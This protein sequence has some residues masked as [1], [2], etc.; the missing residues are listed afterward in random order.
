MKEEQPGRAAQN[1]AAEAIHERSG[2]LL[3]ELRRKKEAGIPVEREQERV[4]RTACR[5][6]DGLREQLL[7]KSISQPLPPRMQY[8][9]IRDWF[10]ARE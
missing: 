8:A 9:L 6:M 2:S 1:I 7:E 4:L 3:R 10:S 5:E